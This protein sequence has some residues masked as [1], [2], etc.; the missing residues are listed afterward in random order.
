HTGFQR[1]HFPFTYLGC[2][3]YR[4]RTTT[5]LFSALFDKVQK[6]LAGWKG[7][8]LS[9]G[10]RLTLIQSVLNSQPIHLFSLLNRPSKTMQI[11]HAAYQ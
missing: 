1:G 9:M 7:K 8:L 5:S 10:G 11:C 2:P 3:I 4:G 6:K